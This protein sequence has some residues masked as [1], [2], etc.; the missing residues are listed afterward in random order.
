MLLKPPTRKSNVSE[1]CFPRFICFEMMQSR[2]EAH[3]ALKHCAINLVYPTFEPDITYRVTLRATLTTRALL[4]EC[5]LA[6]AGFRYHG[7]RRLWSCGFSA[8]SVFLSKQ[9][10]RIFYDPSQFSTSRFCSRS[11][12]FEWIFRFI[13]SLNFKSY[14]ICILS[15]RTFSH[16]QPKWLGGWVFCCSFRTCLCRWFDPSILSHSTPPWRIKPQSNQTVI[17][18][19]ALGISHLFQCTCIFMIFINLVRIVLNVA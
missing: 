5:A 17:R 13:T 2:N 9:F 18:W 14:K 6:L 1:R 10:C 19:R 15:D 12:W 4:C 7:T 3:W 16:L 8:Y 11:W